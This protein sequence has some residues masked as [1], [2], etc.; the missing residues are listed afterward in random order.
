MQFTFSKKIV[1]PGLSDPLYPLKEQSHYQV[2]KE[3]K[4][5]GD[6][7]YTAK[8]GVFF[9]E[10]NEIGLAIHKRVFL[11]PKVALIAKPSG[12]QIGK[13]YLPFIRS[14]LIHNT[15]ELILGNVN[16]WFRKL[17]PNIKNSLFKL[18]IH[19]HCK[20]DLFNENEEIIYS[21]KIK[22]PA[23]FNVGNTTPKIPFEGAI[24]CRSDNLV[25]MFA[26]FYL[27]EK[28]LEEDGWI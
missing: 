8:E 2:Q 14:G 17:R 12:Q 24:Q 15:D 3:G 4:P 28:A 22:Y 26:G 11:L 13:F 18:S 9:C 23:G 6:F 19:R 16:Y 27:I 7:F 20:F 5:V 25:A 21:F 10:G 1:N